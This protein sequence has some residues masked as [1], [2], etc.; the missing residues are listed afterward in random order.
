MSTRKMNLILLVQRHMSGFG[1]FL[2][3]AEIIKAKCDDIVPHVTTRHHALYKQV[4]YCPRPSLYVAFYQANR[5][6][7]LRGKCFHGERMAKSEQYRALEKNGLETLPWQTILPGQRYNPAEWGTYVIV[8][9]DIGKM[10]KDVKIRKASRVQYEKDC[11]DNTPHLI[12]KFLH[13]GKQPESYR[14]LTFFGETLYLQKSINTACGSLLN[15]PS[16][17]DE[18]GG[19]NPVATAAKGKAELVY[20]QDVMDYAKQIAHRAFPDIPVLGQDIVRDPITGKLYCLEVNPYGSTWHF[21][22]RVG[23][24]I[25]SVNGINFEKQFNAFEKT[26][27]ILIRRT[28]EFS[29]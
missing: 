21:S 12:Q 28:R 19:H 6:K 4:M 29:R 14:A 9:P 3:I 2:K 10:G 18:I 23:L 7:P 16:R 13:T 1:D 22:G 17:S 24:A 25:Q 20:D 15:D 27:E 5:F 26:A 11:P 8:K